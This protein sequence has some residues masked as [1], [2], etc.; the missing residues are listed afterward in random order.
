MLTIRDYFEIQS[1]FALN[2]YLNLALS[3]IKGTQKSFILS[4]CNSTWCRILHQQKGNLELYFAEPKPSVKHILWFP[5]YFYLVRPSC[6][7]GCEIILMLSRCFPPQW[8][9][10]ERSLYWWWWSPLASSTCSSSAACHLQSASFYRASRGTIELMSGTQRTAAYDLDWRTQKFLPLSVFLQ[11]FPSFSAISVIF[12]NVRE[13][14]HNFVIFWE[15]LPG[16]KKHVVSQIPEFNFFAGLAVPL[17]ISISSQTTHIREIKGIH[18]F[19]IFSPHCF[20]SLGQYPV[21]HPR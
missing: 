10:S 8:L 6:N 9:W 13:N 3:V 5:Y 17:F 2:P 1:I 15:N 21:K 20:Q 12:R 11:K 7:S 19:A 18:F 16:R 14:F 4:V